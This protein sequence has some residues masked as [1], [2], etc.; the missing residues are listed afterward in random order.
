MSPLRKV[1]YPVVG[2]NVRARGTQ[3]LRGTEK[4]VHCGIG[5]VAPT[6]D[7]EERTLTSPG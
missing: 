7:G 3:W 4:G 1:V 6:E 2:H 5:M